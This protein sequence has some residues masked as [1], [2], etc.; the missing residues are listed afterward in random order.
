M[1]AEAIKSKFHDSDFFWNDNGKLQDVKYYYV[2]DFW[3][4]TKLFKLTVINKTNKTILLS[5]QK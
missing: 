3:V 4:G 2:E 5:H 1:K